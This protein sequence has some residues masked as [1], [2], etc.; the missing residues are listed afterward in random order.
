ME[1]IDLVTEIGEA[2]IS[3]QH[4]YVKENAVN[5]MTVHSAK[6]LEFPVVF[7]VNL[8]NERFPSRDK[9]EQ[10]PI[11][12]DLIKETL[13]KGEFHIQEER[14]LF[15]VGITRAKDK[16]YFTASDFYGDGVRKKKFPLRF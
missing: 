14:R 8:V 6:G 1:W 2:P 4:D 15:Y 9:S 11:P 10:I 16:L 12:E 3:Y 13:P 5:I 7:L